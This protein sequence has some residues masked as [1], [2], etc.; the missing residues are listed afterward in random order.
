MKICVAGGTGNISSAIVQ[1]LIFLGH[2]VTIFDR[3]KTKSAPDG[4]KQLIGDRHIEDNFV[5]RI[6]FFHQ[7]KEF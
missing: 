6:E 1:R 5:T 7:G 2:E 3:G 4:C